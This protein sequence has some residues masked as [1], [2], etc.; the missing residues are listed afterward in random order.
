MTNPSE[1]GKDSPMVTLI[2]GLIVMIGV[3]YKQNKR[4]VKT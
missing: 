1:K 4:L 2:E 3:T